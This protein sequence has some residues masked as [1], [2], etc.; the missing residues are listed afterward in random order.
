V[1][2]HCLSFKQRHQSPKGVIDDF[3]RHS[4]DLLRLSRGQVHHPHPVDKRNALRLAAR[5]RQSNR[6]PREARELTALRDRRHKNI[7]EPIEVSGG[8]HKR[9]T[10][11]TAHLMTLY[12]VKTHCH[13]VYVLHASRDGLCPNHVEPGDRVTR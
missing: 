10:C 6:E 5:V 2:S 8:E 4:L 7:A 11:G 1:H 9:R 12:R 13:D 3:L